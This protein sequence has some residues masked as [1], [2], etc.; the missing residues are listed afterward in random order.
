MNPLQRALI[1]K[2]GHDHGFEYVLR[3]DDDAVHLASARH[4]AQIRVVQQDGLYNLEIISS[5]GR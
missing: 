1:D 2:A 5:N 4:R 3:A